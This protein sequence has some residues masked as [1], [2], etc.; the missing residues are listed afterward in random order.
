[1]VS[2]MEAA[3]AG[4]LIIGQLKKALPKNMKSALIPA[5]LRPMLDLCNDFQKKIP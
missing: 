3:V 4:S 2:L 1:M 5:G